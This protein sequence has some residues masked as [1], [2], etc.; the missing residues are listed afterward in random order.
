MGALLR[1]MLVFLFPVTALVLSEPLLGLV[2]SMFIGQFCSTAELAALGPANIVISFSH[3]CFASIQ[4]ATMHMLGRL[5]RTGDDASAQQL[6]SSALGLAL[7][8]GAFVLVTLT[9][10]SSNLVMATGVRDPEVIALASSFLQI[11]GAGQM[12]VLVTLV[13]QSAFLAQQDPVAPSAI[14]VAAT[15]FSIAGHFALVANAGWGLTGAAISTSACNVLSALSLLALLNVRG[16]LRSAINLPRLRDLQGLLATM[17]PLSVKFISKNCCY[18]V[19]QTTATSILDVTHLAAHQAIFSAWGFC[20][21]WLAPVEQAVLAMAPA[22]A[23]QVE[24]RAIMVVGM[25]LG[26]LIGTIGGLAVSCVA[27]FGPHLLTQDPLLWPLV[28]MVAGQAFAS[29]VLT[30]IDVSSNAVNIVGGDVNYVATSFVVTLGIVS[31]YMALARHMGWGFLG[32]W[33]GIVVFFAT[34][35]LQSGILAVRKHI[36]GIGAGAGTP[37]DAEVSRGERTAAGGKGEQACEAGGRARAEAGGEEEAAQGAGQQQPEASV[38]ASYDAQGPGPGLE[39]LQPQHHQP[40][41]PVAND[42][43][44]GALDQEGDAPAGDASLAQEP[45]QKSIQA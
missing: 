32:V 36:M 19:I 31:A 27:A 15:L 35:A 22:A 20:S 17:A 8:C 34:R 13:C 33:N 44:G 10:F 1:R 23:S 41:L 38:S 25:G 30:G 43:H 18:I 29:M 39:P 7:V 4:I 21:F 40:P 9:L 3:Y 24:R 6:L 12:G 42:Q 14:G 37:L 28:G 26:V 2:T 11:R 5:L 16:R 45:T